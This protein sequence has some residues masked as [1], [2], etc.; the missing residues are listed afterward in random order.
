MT[1]PLRNSESCFPRISMLTFPSTEILEKQKFSS[2]PDQSLKLLYAVS[3]GLGT[4]EF[5][6][7]EIDI[8]SGLDFSSGPV[9]FG[10]EKAA[11]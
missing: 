6:L 8:E 10:G 5:T 11:N 2:S 3:Q 9:A 4:T 1:G 7:A